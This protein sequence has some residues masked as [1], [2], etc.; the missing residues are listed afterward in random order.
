M[1]KALLKAAISLVLLLVIVLNVSLPSLGATETPE[2]GT[3]TGDLLKPG[4]LNGDGKVDLGDVVLLL[5]HVLF[6]ELYPLAGSGSGTGEDRYVYKHVVILG[7]DG[8]GSFFKQANTPNLDRIFENGSVTYTARAMTPSISGQNW[9]SILHGVLPE[10]H[11]CTN[12]SSSPYDSDSVFPSIFRVVR[13]AD[14]SCSLAS[15]NNWTTI[16]RAILEANLGIFMDNG[17]DD[18]LAGK[19]TAYL[20]KNQPKLMFVQFDSVDGAGHSY[21]SSSQIYLDQISHIDTLI[22]SIYDKMVET[23]M[24]EDTLLIVVPDHGHTPTG[25]HGG[26]SDEEMNVMIAVTG[27]TVTKGEMGEADLRDVASIALYALG[28]EQPATYTSRVPAG[29]FPEVGETERPVYTAPVIHRYEHEGD[30][31]PSDDSGKTLFDF[32]GR[33]SIALY[34]P[35]DGDLTEKTGTHTATQKDKL[36]FIDGYYGQGAN[37]MDGCIL[38]DYDP[39]TSSFSVSCWMKVTNK[40]EDPVIFGNKDWNAGGNIG[41]VISYRGSDIKFNLGDGTLRMDSSF[42]IPDDMVNGWVPVIFVADRATGTIALSVDFGELQTY[43]IRSELRNVSFNGIGSINFGQD[44]TGSYPTP[45]SATL[46][47][48]VIYN[49]ALTAD[50]IAAL[51]EYYRGDRVQ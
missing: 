26:P 35:L 39:G 2:M 6:P 10:F 8:G 5:Q 12:S 25:G 42:T 9:G 46:D 40:I 36:Y 34:M 3:G 4:D 16:N 1:K 45:L 51:R 27:K 20:E 32:I 19:I 29:I 7:V 33:D 15:F 13:E 31:T 43:A 28:I 11:N 18:T 50:D 17:D 14:P 44:G 41:F 37:V 49:R 38:T 48:L 47:E 22:G 30:P 23:G 21:G 24:M